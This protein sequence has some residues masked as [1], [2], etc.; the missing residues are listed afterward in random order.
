MPSPG[1]G[2]AHFLLAVDLVILRE[3]NGLNVCSKP[4]R[5]SGEGLL[6]AFLP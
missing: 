1:N 5:A 4:G 3:I 6:S 2:A